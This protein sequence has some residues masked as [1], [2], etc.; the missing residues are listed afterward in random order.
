MS[1]NP[2]RIDGKAVVLVVVVVVLFATILLPAVNAGFA[3][4]SGAAAGTEP[5]G[6]GVVLAGVIGVLTAAFAGIG[7]AAWLRRRRRQQRNIP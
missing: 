4:I 1:R 7:V 2:K 5:S 6:L 3:L